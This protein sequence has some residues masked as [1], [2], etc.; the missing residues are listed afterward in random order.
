MTTKYNLKQDL[1]GSDN[2]AQHS[3]LHGF[4]VSP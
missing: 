2:S 3:E 1:K 4:W